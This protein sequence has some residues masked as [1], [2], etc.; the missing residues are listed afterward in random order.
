M[1]NKYLYN[2][3]LI[4]ANSKREAIQVIAKDDNNEF[5]E[6]VKVMKKYGTTKVGYPNSVSVQSNKSFKVENKKYFLNINVDC[7]Y[8]YKHKFNAYT[9]SLKLISNKGLSY[10]NLNQ[11]LSTKTIKEVQ[12]FVS[13][14]KIYEHKLCSC[15]EQYFK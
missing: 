10:L 3:E 14:M 12:K 4:T 7:A 2:G 8:G 5:N 9:C 13:K 15:L 6:L 1:K 11:E